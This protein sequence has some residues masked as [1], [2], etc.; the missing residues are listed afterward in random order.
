LRYAIGGENENVAALNR[1]PPVIDRQIA[2]HAE[3]S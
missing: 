3:G 1:L 2:L